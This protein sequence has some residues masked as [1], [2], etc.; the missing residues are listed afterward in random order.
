MSKV[1][2]VIRLAL[3]HLQVQRRLPARAVGG[4]G[5][6][7]D[8]EVHE[9]PVGVPAGQLLA[10]VLLQLVLVVLALLEPP[11]SFG[12]VAIWLTTVLSVKCLLPST[13]TWLMATR[14]P[15]FT[16]NTT[17][18]LP[19][20]LGQLQGLHLGGVVAGIL[21]ERVDRGAGLL[22]GVAV[23]RPPFGQLDLA[24]APSPRDSRSTPRTAQRSSTGRSLTLKTRTSL[25]PAV[26][27]STTTSSNWPVRNRLAMARWMSR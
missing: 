3:V 18:I 15:S 21:V 9:A 27:C 17:R 4:Q 7:G 16:S 12:R 19:S 10:H 13:S 24:L 11:E 2:T 1:P 6:A 5:V 23:E 8:L 20:C 26:R 22:D 14:L 25:S